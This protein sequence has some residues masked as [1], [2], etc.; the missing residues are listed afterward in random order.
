MPGTPLLTRLALAGALLVAVPTAASAAA[1]SSTLVGRAILPAATSSPAPA[2]FARQPVGGFSNL[3]VDPRGRP[4]DYLAMTDNGYGTKAN[5]PTFLLRVYRVRPDFTT[6]RGGDGSVEVLDRTQLRDPRGFVGFPIQTEGTRT[7]LLTGADF[8]IES[9][10]IDGEGDWWFGDEFGPFLLHTNDRGVLLEAPIPTPG[11]KSP[12]SPYLAA[13]ETPTLPSSGGFEAMAISRSGRYLYPGLEKALVGDTDPN[14]RRFLQ[15][16]LRAHRYTGR[17]YDYRTDAPGNVLGDLTALDA[18]R[19]LVVER[20][21]KDGAATSFDR[22]FVIDLRRVD[23]DGF[24]VKRSVIDLLDIA[25][26]ARLSERGGRPGDLG[27]GDPFSFPYITTEAVLPLGGDR[28][29]LVN[30]NNFAAGGGRNPNLPV[31]NDFIVVKVPGLRDAADEPDRPDDDDND[32]AT[33]GR[34]DQIRF[35]TFNA[36]LNRGA[37]GRLVADLAK[38]G[39]AQADAVAEIIQRVRPDVLLINEFDYDAEGLAARR[40]GRNYL[41]V[42]HGDAAPIRYPYRFVAPS[43]TGV[44]TGLDLDNSGTVGGGNDAFGF[45]DFPGQY[46]MLV[47]SKY[48]IDQGA[49]RT[50]REFRWADMPGA[51][52]PDD[53]ATPAPADW[54]SPAE[55]AIFRLSSKSHWDVPIRVGAG[56]TIHFLTSHP[57]PPTFDGPE[58]RNGRRNHDEI[59][60]TADYVDPSRSSYIYDDDGQSGGL[61]RGSDFVIAGDQNSDPLDGDS[62][63]G[64]AQ[65]LL[66]S[67]FVDSRRAPTSVGG[68]EQARLQ[69]GANTTHRGDPATDT[70][71]FNDNPAP[72]NLRA[73]YV[74]G[75]RTLRPVGG[76]VFWPA[77]ADP[78]LSLVG[79]FPFPSSDHRMVWLDVVPRRNR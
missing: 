61:P 49:A 13:G 58:D 8:D 14:R 70:A 21:F 78:L 52:L 23:A 55:L 3:L 45:G 20:D 7:R 56:R 17:R 38:P 37:D 15:F 29:A 5:S 41:S 40:F 68:P 4:G 12:D 35:A 44:P 67:P 42:R 59:R 9:M 50:F 27:I 77:V 16:D 76:G 71:D 36:S 48:P 47:L 74:L 10:R 19:Y 32:D 62:V 60:F 73:D 30:D 57:T 46:G 24:L 53:A 75:S 39:N 22:V 69:G 33:P 25:D 26:P 18:N 51:L 65:Q 1:P 43:N 6:R 2:P 31:D 54:Y 63:P 66:D 11:V 34:D 72:G 64:S 79:T 28:V